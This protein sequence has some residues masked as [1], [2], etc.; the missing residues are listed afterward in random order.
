MPTSLTKA[1][2]IATDPKNGSVITDLEC[3][4][5]PTDYTFAKK[6]TWKTD[7]LKGNQVPKADFQGGGITTMTFQLFFDT[8]DKGT[9]VRTD[10]TDKL[11]TMMKIVSSDSSKNVG[12][13][14]YV[15]FH[16]GETWSFKGV[17]TSVDLKFTLFTPNGTPVRA[18]ANVGLQQALDEKIYA[19]QNPTSGGDGARASRLVQPGDTLDLI[20]YQEYGDPTM[21]RLLAG[22]NQLEDPRALRSGQ[23]LVI[24]SP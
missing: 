9:D 8:Y 3:L 16:W 2:L 7:A 12:Q 11:L 20:A 4:F 15:E 6:N 5:N 23:R 13:P 17:V 19:G 14:P 18:T 10:C 22:A 24:P 21:W 1:H